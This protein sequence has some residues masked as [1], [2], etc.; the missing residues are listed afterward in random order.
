M[1]HCPKLSAFPLRSALKKIAANADT[2]NYLRKVSAELK[3]KEQRSGCLGRCR[4][5]F[6]SD[7]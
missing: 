2:N 6:D 1:K 7:F 4:Q 5:F 3:P